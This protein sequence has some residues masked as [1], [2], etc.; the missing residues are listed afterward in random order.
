MSRLKAVNR[1]LNK[2]LLIRKTLNFNSPES[3][4]DTRYTIL[5]M[6]RKKTIVDKDMKE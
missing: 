5:Q 3:I 6:K 1:N 2:N 4:L